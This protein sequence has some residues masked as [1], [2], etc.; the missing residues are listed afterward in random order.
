LR[1]VA[2][3][4][5]RTGMDVHRTLLSALVIA[6]AVVSDGAFAPSALRQW[7]S[8]APEPV[9]SFVR[10]SLADRFRAG[11]IPDLKILDA[12][13]RIGV[14]SVMPEAH[15]TLTDA[16]LPVVEG[17]QFFLLSPDDAQA[18][19]DRE[20]KNVT[21]VTVDLPEPDSDPATIVIGVGMIVPRH[22]GVI[23]LC[24]CAGKAEFRRAHDAWTFAKWSYVRCS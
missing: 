8:T 9:Q 6:S 3:R 12:S 4:G 10:A 19:A 21:F 1:E 7:S 24:C 11:D 14:R 18:T 15:Q 2:P 22:S 13:R 16:A 5:A 23:T 17:Y 20:K